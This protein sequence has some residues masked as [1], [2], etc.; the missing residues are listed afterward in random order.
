[1]PTTKNSRGLGTQSS[2][3]LTSQTTTLTMEASPKRTSE[4]PKRLL[5]EAPHRWTSH[6]TSRTTPE[7]LWEWPSGTTTT[8]SPQDP[9][10]MTSETTTKQIHQTSLELSAK[11]PASSPTVSI[12]GDS[13]EWEEKGEGCKGE[14]PQLSDLRAFHLPQAPSGFVWPMGPTSVL[15]G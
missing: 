12:P 8:L 2:L 4:L 3:E 11:T 7:T 14:A 15:A 9:R 10:E 13:G 1:M 5:T 6:I